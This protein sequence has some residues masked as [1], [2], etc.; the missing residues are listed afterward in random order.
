LQAT[1]DHGAREIRADI[2]TISISSSKEEW[3]IS[4]PGNGQRRLRV[5]GLRWERL[6]VIVTDWNQCASAREVF[7]EGNG[8]FINI[9][10][11]RS[12]GQIIYKVV[13]KRASYWR[14]KF[15]YLLVI[16]AFFENVFYNI[17]YKL[18]C[19]LSIQNKFSVKPGNTDTD[20]LGFNLKDK[21]IDSYKIWEIVS[22]I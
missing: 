4:D 13:G 2:S 19:V 8:A 10:K 12:V 17:Q 22:S 6:E 16:N 21:N 20:T 11:H 14:L 15:Y 1:L 3:K 9:N 7:A 18:Q 5:S